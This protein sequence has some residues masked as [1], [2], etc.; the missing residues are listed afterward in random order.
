[1]R[2]R[3]ITALAALVLV[4]QAEIIDRIAATID[5]HVIT[6]SELRREIVLTAFLN[7]DKPDFS[8][9]NLRRT[10]ERLVEQALI[11][12]EIELMRYPGPPPSAVDEMLAQVR[13]ERL[14]DEAQYRREL[15]EYRIRE[16]DVRAHLERQAAVLRFIDLRFKPGVQVS[17][18]DLQE[19]YQKRYLPELRRRGVKPEPSFDEARAACEELLIGER[20]DAT[21]DEWIAEAKQRTRIE[22]RAEALQ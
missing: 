3:Q 1:M 19:F 2:V 4:A 22:L 18:A 7:G 15:A 14:R 13:R 6:A 21:V 20:V 9:Q 5:S 10:A 11:R 8:A 12:R 17:E 16:Q